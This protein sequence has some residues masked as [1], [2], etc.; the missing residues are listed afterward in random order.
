MVNSIKLLQIYLSASQILVMGC[1]MIKWE[2]FLMISFEICALFLCQ[3]YYAKK[4]ITSGIV[5]KSSSANN[6]FALVQKPEVVCSFSQVSDK[7]LHRLQIYW[8]LL[9]QWFFLQKLNFFWKLILYKTSEG[10]LLNIGCFLLLRW[11]VLS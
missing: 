1:K 2:Q 5:T 10:L 9:H 8:K 7:F 11:D 3:M 4:P 6:S